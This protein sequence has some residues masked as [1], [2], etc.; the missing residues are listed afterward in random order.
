[1]TEETSEIEPPDPSP[2]NLIYFLNGKGSPKRLFR[3]AEASN[4]EHT[5]LLKLEAITINPEKK[6]IFEYNNKNEK[7]TCIE[8]NSVA[9]ELPTSR[10]IWGNPKINKDSIYCSKGPY[11][12]NCEIYPKNGRLSPIN[13]RDLESAIRAYEELERKGIQQTI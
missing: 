4:R 12:P 11:C 6:I 5:Y 8:C 10:T 7:Y 2:R 9:I 1:M 13:E 3:F